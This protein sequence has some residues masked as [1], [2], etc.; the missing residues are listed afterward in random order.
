M[1][2]AAELATG[3]ELNALSLA[4]R[5]QR[6][7]TL[8]KKLE[9]AG[10]YDQARRALSEF[11]PDCLQSPNVQAL[12][13][14]TR[15]EVLLRTGTLAGWI[16]STQQLE[17]HQETAK[18]LIT[19]SLELFE[20]LGSPEKA[21]EARGELGLCYWREGAYDEARIHLATALNALQGQVELKTTLLIRAGI[22]EVWAQ[23]TSEALRLY[24]E[25]AQ[26]I[27]QSDDDALKAIGV[28]R[29]S[30]CTDR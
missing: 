30:V 26:L 29:T 13:P 2:I 18:D 4:E 23:R 19:Q 14:E 28:C 16:G 6:S 27:D 25:A 12:D 8:A 3:N 1:K 20:Q 7:C 11:W 24:Y 10:D 9:K 22:V 21:A 5:A 17:G 15:G